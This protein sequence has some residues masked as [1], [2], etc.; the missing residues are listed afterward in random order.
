VK[1][2]ASD[3]FGPPEERVTWRKRRQI[4]K[5]ALAY[6]TNRGLE[7]SDCRF[8]VVSVI[9][10]AGETEIRHIENAFWLDR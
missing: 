5:V 10:S 8:D 6:I 7:R 4:G 2:A 9:R 3:R 1:S